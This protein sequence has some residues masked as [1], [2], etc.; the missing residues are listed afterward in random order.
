MIRFLSNKAMLE[1]DL[2]EWKRKK[3]GERIEA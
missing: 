2:L 3:G 1:Y